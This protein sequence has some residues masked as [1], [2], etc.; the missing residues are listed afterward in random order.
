M[1][2]EKKK[3]KKRTE[4]KEIDKHENQN[5]DDGA[6]NSKCLLFRHLIFK[7]VESRHLGK[8]EQINVEGGVPR[9]KE[10]LRH[11]PVI[12]IEGFGHVTKAAVTVWCHC[13]LGN[14]GVGARKEHVCCVLG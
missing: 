4:N 3:Q 9:K 5:M 1:V 7:M 11:K 13:E 2:S 6:R 12:Q 14:A 8:C 10:Y